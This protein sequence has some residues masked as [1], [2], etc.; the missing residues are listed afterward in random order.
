MKL[1][2]LVD[3]FFFIE[4][5]PNYTSV[6]LPEFMYAIINRICYF[7]L[8]HLSGRWLIDWLVCES[9][10]VFVFIFGRFCDDSR[11]FLSTHIFSYRFSLASIVMHCDEAATQ[12]NTIQYK[13]FYAVII[14]KFYRGWH[15][16]G[17]TNTQITT[18][19]IVVKNKH[20]HAH[21]HM[22][23]RVHL[24][25]I[26]EYEVNSLFQVHQKF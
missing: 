15:K 23:A 16:Y 9:D 18:K 2:F 13:Q 21:V 20:A 26:I 12:H 6:V 8:S 4:Y 25:Y 10:F 3:F 17:K 19:N 5:V 11:L 1:S 22:C 7:L 24:P 14:K